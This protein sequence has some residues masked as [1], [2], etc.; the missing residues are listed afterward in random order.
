M[1]GV[2]LLGTLRPVR[3]VANLNR[4]IRTGILDETS[5]SL[6]TSAF[7]CGPSSQNKNGGHPSSG[8]SAAD[9]STEN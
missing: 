8:L 5:V 9:V 4:A 3:L 1:P 7:P 2:V 6:R